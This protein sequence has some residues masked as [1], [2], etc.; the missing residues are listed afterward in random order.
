MKELAQKTIWSLRDDLTAMQKGKM[1]LTDRINYERALLQIKFL[2]Q[3][4]SRI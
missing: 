4:I 1:T 2:E 3:L